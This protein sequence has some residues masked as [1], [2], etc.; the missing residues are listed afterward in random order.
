MHYDFPILAQ[1]NRFFFLKK[2]FFFPA[3]TLKNPKVYCIIKRKLALDVKTLSARG[4]R[5]N[6]RIVSLHLLYCYRISILANGN[7]RI[8]NAT[9]SDAGLYTCVARNQFGVASSTG[10]LTVKGISSFL[11]TFHHCIVCTL[12]SKSSNQRCHKW[13]HFSNAY[14][15]LTTCGCCLIFTTA[16]V[17]TLLT[18]WIVTQHNVGWIS[19]NLSGRMESEPNKNLLNTGADPG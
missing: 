7:L 3:K 9:K 4:G 5:E 12:F 14:F 17:Y 8:W 10:T 6:S 2:S 15:P 19:T 16:R 11:C 18:G 13:T 1:Q